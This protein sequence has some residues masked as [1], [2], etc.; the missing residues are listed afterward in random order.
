MRRG[1]QKK[2]FK[3][4]AVLVALASVSACNG[5][6]MGSGSMTSATGRGE[7]GISLKVLCDADTD[8]VSGSLSFAD[9]RAAVGVN[10]AVNDAWA[11]YYVPQLSVAQELDEPEFPDYPWYG[12]MCD[13][14]SE[15][16]AYLGHFSG[17]IG[18]VRDSG[19][20]AVA[21]DLYGCGDRPYVDIYFDGARRSYEN[22]GC[23]NMSSIRQVP[24][25]SSSD[26]G[27]VSRR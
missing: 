15:E 18:G 10:A 3:A 2:T 14:D 16:G 9:S 27:Y 22:H 24:W 23:V 20:M 21:I 4:G 6:F 1:W 17:T 11:D 7:A 26:Y 12:E 19:M 13:G 25:A 8:S 5:S